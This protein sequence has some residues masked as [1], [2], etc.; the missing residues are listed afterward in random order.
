MCVSSLSWWWLPCR[1][2]WFLS[3]PARCPAGCPFSVFGSL[4]AFPL[5]PCPA[6]FLAFP[7][8]WVSF[9]GWCGGWLLCCP[10]LRCWRGFSA[11]FWLPCWVFLPCFCS[12]LPRLSPLWLC[13]L[14]L[15]PSWW[16][17]GWSW[18]SWLFW[19]LFSSSFLFLL[20][21]LHL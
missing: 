4:F 8:L 5:L 10:L 6:V 19:W 2:R 14:L 11:L 3:F 17:P 9:R 12:L 21:L 13:S 20:F 7:C 16:L 15:L 18:W 1:G